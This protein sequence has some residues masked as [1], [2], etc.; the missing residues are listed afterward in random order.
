MAV[1][2]FRVYERLKEDAIEENKEAGIH[3]EKKIYARYLSR[4]LILASF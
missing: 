4:G 2:V 3:D 1:L